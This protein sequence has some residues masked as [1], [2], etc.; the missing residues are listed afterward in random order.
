MKYITN[1]MLMKNYLFFVAI[2]VCCAVSNPSFAGDGHKSLSALWDQFR[3]EKNEKEKTTLLLQIGDACLDQGG[4]AQ[5]DSVFQLALTHAFVHLNGD[6]AALI[7]VYK[8][9][10][11]KDYTLARPDALDIALRMENIA[12]SNNNDEWLYAACRV[13][14]KIYTL[15]DKPSVALGVITRAN[16][17]ANILND[18]Y[19]KAQSL[20]ELGA[21]REQNNDKI[22]A[23]KN[24]RD[25]LV[26]ASKIENDDLVNNAYGRL[27]EFFRLNGNFEKA[28]EYKQK[29]FAIA[30]K[31]KPVD[32]EKLMWLYNDLS[33]ILFGSND[34][35]QGSRIWWQVAGFALSHHLDRLKDEA[36]S[37]Y[38]GYLVRRE[39]FPELSELYT[40]EFPGELQLLARNS[41]SQYC[42]LKAYM[43]ES[44][45][46]YD[47]SDVY[48]RQAESFIGRESSNNY[49]ISNFYKRYGEFLYKRG[50][51]AAAKEKFN[52]SYSYAQN[53]R[54]FPYLADATQFLDSISYREH[55]LAAAY[56]FEKLNRAYTDS[57][58]LVAREGEVL[59]L[60]IDNENRQ[61]EVAQAK[62]RENTENR[63]KLQDIG[64]LIFISVLFTVLVMLGS[65]RVPKYVIKLVGFISFI[66]LFEF[67]VMI[68]DTKVENF[69]RGEPWKILF[70][71]LVIISILAPIHHNL[72]HRLLSYLFDHKILNPENMKLR[73]LI[74]R[75]RKRIKDEEEHKHGE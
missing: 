35:A 65:F 64:I 25:G 74:A 61:N 73:P 30:L 46:N 21:C 55:D 60:E 69:T 17:Y 15:Q 19:L 5:R 23:F 26:I 27:S 72:E 20:L 3:D 4:P 43:F 10:F 40:R 2:I 47:S 9:Y 34:G 54:Y 6:N 63:H 49:F 24:Y 70:F 38:R 36:F 66:L 16:Y 7:A 28:R 44:E 75:L 39:L 59:M 42:R 41:P 57:E 68:T 33:N 37:N 29:Q 1:C 18:D 71:K 48:F 58:A 53:A 50:D 22:D 67:I 12:K 51:L 13:Q 32:S 62:E 31:E 52:L 14:Y 45:N 11:S 8:W 56:H